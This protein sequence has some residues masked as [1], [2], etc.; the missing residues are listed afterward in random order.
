MSTEKGFNNQK[1]FGIAQ[2]KT[3]NSVSSDKYGESVINKSLFSVSAGTIVSIL[4]GSTESD[5]HTLYIEMTAHGARENDILRMTSGNLSS[6]EFDIL[7]IID[8]NIF[9][10]FNIGS[11]GG[12][13]ILPVVADTTRIMRWITPQVDSA[14]NLIISLPAGGATSANQ[15]LEIA[16]LVDINTNTK[17]LYTMG[18]P[19]IG[20]DKPIIDMSVT[21]IPVIGVG[22]GVLLR[23]L[24]A[25][26]LPSTVKKIKVAENQGLFLL[27]STDIDGT[28][29]IGTSSL[30]GEEIDCNLGASDEIY[31]Q[32]LTTASVSGNLLVQF[33][34]EI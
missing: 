24:G 31:V 1:K 21:N 4:K 33:E 17:K 10:V 13:E 23:D 3:I 27:F 32:S 19:F 25:N 22:N 11:A 28:D 30:G 20:T 8:A 16:E 18:V 26:P 6:W 12:V 15:V 29:I 14:G 9:T 34:G 5:S 7:E 2:H